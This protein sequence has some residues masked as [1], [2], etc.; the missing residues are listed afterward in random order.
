ML[1][2]DN[3]PITDISERK[4]KILKVKKGYNPN[5]SSM[6]SIVFSF[7]PLLLC[8]STLF[9]GIAGVVFSFFLKKIN[10]ESENNQN[11]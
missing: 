5:S 6:G 2:I 8:A 4:G 3:V 1:N 9:A 11:E 7:T 10:K